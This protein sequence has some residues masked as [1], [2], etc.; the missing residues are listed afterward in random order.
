MT[1][2]GSVESAIRSGA[3]ATLIDAITLDDDPTSYNS[4]ALDCS[5]FRN[6]LL[7][8]AIDSTS[9]PTTLQLLVQFSDDGGT[10]WWTYKQ[11]PFAALF[12]EDADTATEINECFEGKC[13]GRLMR[14][15][16]V[17]VGTTSSAKFKVT[18]KV[19]LFN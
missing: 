8:V 12:W 13:G 4:D 15:R 16:A 10:I 17:G 6:F 2:M 9:T 3:I 7:Y 5:G 1:K 18:A 11:G 19:E 14:I